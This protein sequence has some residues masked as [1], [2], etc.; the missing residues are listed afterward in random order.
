M[1][2]T[3]KNYHWGDFTQGLLE[4]H[5]D[6]FDST[7][8]LDE[9]GFVTEGPGFNLF[10]IRDGKVLTPDRGILHG[11]TRQSALDLCV[12]KG[13]EAAVVALRRED[14]LSADEAFCTSTAGGI[15]PISQFDYHIMSNGRP[16]PIS[17]MLKDFY[18]EQH[19]A[20]WHMT[21]VGYDNKESIKLSNRA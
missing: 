18:W 2:P 19:R 3:I 1:D 10:I 14:L 17:S 5:D 11:I 13:L 8:L 6:N 21:P 4:A 20:G 16:G 15:M 7:V 9:E 12:L